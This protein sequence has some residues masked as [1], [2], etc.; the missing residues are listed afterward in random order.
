MKAAECKSS[1]SRALLLLICALVLLSSSVS[2][3]GV[4]DSIM[5]YLVKSIE[6]IGKLVLGWIGNMFASVLNAMIGLYK[7][8]ILWNP[9][10]YSVAPLTESLL[11]LLVPVYVVAFIV[12]G[13]YLIFLST[14][15]SGRARAKGMLQKLIFSLV[16]VTLSMPIYGILLAIS[17]VLSSRILAG[18]TVDGSELLGGLVVISLSGGFAI[19]V[20]FLLIAVLA[21]I[22]IGIRHFLTFL[23]AAIF[24][25]TIFLY[26]FD[27]TKEMGT[28]LMRYT[29]GAIFT[30]VVQAII[31]AVTIFSVNSASK[32][33]GLFATLM[34]LFVA[35]GGF[36]LL[37]LA[38]LIMLGIM[39]WIGGALG[40]LGA[41]VA[42]TP[43]MAAAGGI[44]TAAGGVAA[45]MGAGGLMAGGTVY[46]L[47][48][49]VSAN[50][51]GGGGPSRP[52]IQE[53]MTKGDILAAEKK[54]RQTEA[55]RRQA[56]FDS[57]V[58][59]VRPD[60]VAAAGKQS[61][62]GAGKYSKDSA[63]NLGSF[64][65]RVE[66]E[67]KPEPSHPQGKSLTETAQSVS[68]KAG[69]G[70]LALASGPVGWAGLAGYGGYKIG[71]RLAQTRT[72]Q[73]VVQASRNVGNKVIHKAMVT[74]EQVAEKSVSAGQ[75]V[76]Q[77]ATDTAQWAA[78]TPTA[79]SVMRGADAAR[80]GA[81]AVENR[82]KVGVDNVRENVEHIDSRIVNAEDG[83]WKKGAAKAASGREYVA[84]SRP[85]QLGRAAYTNAVAAKETTVDVANRVSAGID[86]VK[87]AAA[88]RISESSVV[89]GAKAVKTGVSVGVASTQSSAKRYF[90][91]VKKK[92]L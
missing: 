16:L 67:N 60:L 75:A 21:G 76:A 59:G 23:M 20:M 57:N 33:P 37:V 40:G 54:Q 39:K 66:G 64:M 2:A 56:G 62:W 80:K 3:G 86:D 63:Q 25:L 30:Q 68:K 6:Y 11:M 19:P 5:N 58:K 78:Q 28:K 22:S 1:I 14:S 53:K 42:F 87:T 47:G 71:G 52:I 24:P 72:G 4:A 77:T 51:G 34:S 35:M 45:G 70:M 91:N 27:L 32:T 84:Q 50:L 83:V 46:G 88:E 10:P 89:K 9:D 18:V 17:G 65:D 49:S 92:Y 85:G 55:H 15:P 73:K 7:G 44:M 81:V 13:V 90:K 8:L 38:P 82:V 61:D 36:V 69:I 29:I 12:I 48:K 74:A 26:F 43:G 31:L 79:Q 41:V